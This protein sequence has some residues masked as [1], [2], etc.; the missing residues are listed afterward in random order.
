MKSLFYFSSSLFFFSIVPFAVYAQT[1]NQALIEKSF[2]DNSSHTNRAALFAQNANE[3]PKASKSGDRSKSRANAKAKKTK[4]ENVELPKFQSQNDKEAYLKKQAADIVYHQKTNQMGKAL[5]ICQRI[6]PLFNASLPEA[7]TTPIALSCAFIY[8]ENK[9]YKDELRIYDVISS[10]AKETDTK[11][12]ICLFRSTA[13]T[14][15]EAYDEAKTLLESCKSDNAYAPAISGNLA[16]IYMTLGD[17]AKSIASYGDAIQIA[18]KNEHALYGLASALARNGQWQDALQQF[19]KGVARDP[20]FNY[21]TTAFFMPKSEMDYQTAFTKIALHRYPEAAYYLKRYVSNEER[22]PYK[23][24]ANCVL[25]ELEKIE[26]TPWQTP[27]PILLRKMRAAAI[28]A[29]ATYLAFADVDFIPQ[30]SLR[31]DVWIL[32][33]QTGKT[34]KVLSIDNVFIADA[35]FV[36]DSSILRIL[37]NSQRYEIDAAHPEKGYYIYENI[38]KNFP[39]SLTP[40]ATDIL[41]V[42][43][44]NKVSLAPWNSDA[45]HATFFEIPEDSVRVAMLYNHDVIAVSGIQD[46]SFID[47]QSQS[48]VTTLPMQFDVRKIAPHPNKE[49]FALGIQSGTLL[50]DSTGTIQTLVGTPQE[51]TGVDLVAFDPTGTY[52]LSVAG[53]TAEIRLLDELL[54]PAASTWKCRAPNASPDTSISH[55]SLDKTPL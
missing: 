54:T 45:T 34:T 30:T 8:A 13:L 44:S 25:A 39:L 55:A 1:P 40:S 11:N 32:N 20:G 47:T 18:P 7:T 16:E 21:L 2:I 31:S 12:A 37:G 38:S 26:K 28:D 49:L 52:L 24:M 51:N 27:Y 22:L 48:T 15:L 17:L 23:S 5:A 4:N 29:S 6:E 3:T 9:L 42:S 14:R 41:S 19:L 33:T 10:Y 50:V 46:T 53:N 43:P 36:G 35:E